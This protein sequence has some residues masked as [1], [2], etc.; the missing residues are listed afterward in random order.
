MKT[1]HRVALLCVA[2][3]GLVSIKRLVAI[4][5]LFVFREKCELRGVEE[6]FTLRRS[7]CG[8]TGMRTFKAHVK[9]EHNVD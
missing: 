6:E 1:S 5:Q 7:H 2:F 8:V 9:M 4:F 3:N